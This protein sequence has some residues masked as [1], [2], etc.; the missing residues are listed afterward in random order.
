MCITGY[1]LFVMSRPFSVG[2]HI[3]LSGA[4]GVVVD[5]DLL[6]LTLSETNAS[7]QITGKTIVLP[8]S[9]LL[10]AVITNNHGLGSFVI[11]SVRL[12]VPY[13]VNRDA[14]NTIAIQV[15]TELCEPWSKASLRHLKRLDSKALMDSPTNSIQVVWET[16]DI[17]QHWFEIRFLVP[18]AQQE[19]IAQEIQYQLWKQYGSELQAATS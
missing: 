14:L 6:N 13:H 19:Q 16:A 5:V 8:N 1:I 4:Q 9:V 7:H 3:E 10:T 17:K 2:D 15:T 11:G 12:A 18:V